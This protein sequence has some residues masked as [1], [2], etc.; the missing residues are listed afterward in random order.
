MQP[1]HA[2]LLLGTLTV[3]STFMRTQRLLRPL[4]IQ[5]AGPK[6]LR[7]L[8]GSFVTKLYI[9]LFVESRGIHRISDT[10][11]SKKLHPSA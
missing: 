7:P 10:P 1:P 6:K 3:A 4:A 11:Q 5:R 8:I 9:N 2:K